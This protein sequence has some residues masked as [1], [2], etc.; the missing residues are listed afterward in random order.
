M[1]RYWGLRLFELEMRLVESAE[2]TRNEG[3]MGERCLERTVVGLGR[4]DTIVR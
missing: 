4:I 1:N 3:G 2:S